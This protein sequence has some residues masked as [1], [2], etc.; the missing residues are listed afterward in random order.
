MDSFMVNG[1]RWRIERVSADSTYLIDRT[2]TRTVATTDPATM[3][4]YISDRLHGS[5]MARVLIHEIG[6]CVMVSFGLIE[7]L[8]A[9]VYP[10]QWVE[11]E[12]WVCNFLADYGMTAFMIASRAM[13]GDAIRCVPHAMA[14]LAS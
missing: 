10:S 5:M 13:G 11:A 3:T 2:D 7:E 4:V 6:H 8:R 12:E 14:S 1:D 9:M